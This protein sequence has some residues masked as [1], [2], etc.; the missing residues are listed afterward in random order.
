[1]KCGIDEAGRGPLIGPMVMAILC[2]DDQTLRELH[3]K[4]SKQLTPAGRMNI[5][6]KLKEEKHKYLIIQPSEIDSYVKLK[7][8]NVL[9]ENYAVELASVVPPDAEIYVDSFDVNEIR[10][11]EKLKIRTEREIICKHKADVIYP[12]VSGASII[13]K[14]IRDTEIEKLHKIYGDFGSGYPSDSRTIN[15]VKKAIADKKDIN[16]IVRHEWKTYRNLTRKA[17]F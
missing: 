17:Y 12:Q 8:L 4:D 1:M 2:G 14:V 15:F 3:V 5:Y 6:K 16:P 10:L 7:K 11:Q 9:E 13:A